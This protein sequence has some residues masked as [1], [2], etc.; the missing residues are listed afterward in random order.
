MREILFRGK[1]VDNGAWIE[2]YLFSFGKG[3]PYEE[4]YILG[5]L[6]HRDTVYDIWKCAEKVITETVGQWTGLK[7]RNG[8]KI[9]EGDIMHCAGNV[10]EFY[11]DGFCINGDSSLSY[12]TKTEVI[13]NIH[14]NP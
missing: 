1:R 14:D 8:K 5:D 6:D 7:D 12:W 10:V 9:F 11:S 2:G 4:T 13:G 3:T